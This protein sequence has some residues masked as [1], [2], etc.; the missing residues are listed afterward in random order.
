VAAA[1][2]LMA[3]AG[4][5]MSWLRRR[6]IVI[7]KD[8]LQVQVRIAKNRRNRMKR[9]T[10]RVKL[11]WPGVEME[12]VAVLTS[13]LNLVPA[14]ERPFAGLTAAMINKVMT[15][16]VLAVKYTTYSC[17]KRYVKVVGG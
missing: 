3:A 5:R 6:Q 13:F 10:L 14:D 15:T 2:S 9:A 8:L 17:R 1:I 12:D 4:L 7:T 11:H 16:A